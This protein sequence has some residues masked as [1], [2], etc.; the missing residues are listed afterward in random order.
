MWN[1]VVDLRDFYTTRTGQVTRHLVRRAVRHA[2]PDLT[3]QRVLGLGYATPYLRQYLGEA[4]RVLAFMPAAQGVVHWPPEG[5]GRVSLVDETDLPLA[6]FSVDRVVLVHALESSE[7]LRPLMSEVWRVLMGDGRVL[8]VVPNRRSLWAR[9]ERTPFGHGHPYTR[10]QLSKL[11]RETMFTPTHTG[12]ALFVPPTGSRTLLRS[13]PAL[14]RLGGRWCPRLGGAL[15]MEAGKQLYAVKP[16][17][18]R[19]RLRRPVVVPLARPAPRRQAVNRR[20]A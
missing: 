5:P 18:Q 2:W 11:L 16:K 14:E 13:A 19:V 12:Y 6:D 20:C 10:A 15:L 4:E 3:G 9:A 8:V 1:D 17:A 7:A